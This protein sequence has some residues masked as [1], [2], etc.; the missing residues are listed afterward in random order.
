MNL[1]RALWRLLNPPQRHYP[2][3]WNGTYVTCA[4]GYRSAWDW[5]LRHHFSLVGRVG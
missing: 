2:S 3:K 1:L 4:C 5:D